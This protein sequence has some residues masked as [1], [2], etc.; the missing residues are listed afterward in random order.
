MTEENPL[1]RN[2]NFRRIAIL[3]DSNGRVLLLPSG[4]CEA[5]MWHILDL[6][7]SMTA[8]NLRNSVH[9]MTSRRGQHSA[10][11]DDRQRLLLWPPGSKTMVARDLNRWLER[12]KHL[13]QASPDASTRPIRTIRGGVE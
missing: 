3:N 7:S 4:Q 5:G 10:I 9:W 13:A 6:K 1:I 11:R 2:G 8:I 12:N